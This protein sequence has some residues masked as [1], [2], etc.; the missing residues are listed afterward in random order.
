MLAMDMHVC[1][2]QS[3]GIAYNSL[4]GLMPMQITKEVNEASI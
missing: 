1:N 3:Q 4:A 2:V